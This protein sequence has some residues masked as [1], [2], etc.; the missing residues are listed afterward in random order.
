MVVVIILEDWVTQMIE[1]LIR[2]V[3]VVV[4]DIVCDKV[5]YKNQKHSFINISHVITNN[6]Y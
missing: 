1:I 3:V 6:I 5:I 2:E 4:V